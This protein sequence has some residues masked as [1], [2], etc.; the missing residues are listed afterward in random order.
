MNTFHDLMTRYAALHAAGEGESDEAQA[1][2]A[3][4]ISVAPPEFLQMAER[5]AQALGLMP[6]H[7]DGYLMDGS[8]VYTVDGIASRL[9]VTEAEVHDGIERMQA[10]QK[11]AG[12]LVQPL[13]FPADAVQR[14]Q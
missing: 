6:E 14:V 8:P 4:A 10:V 3:K 5:E 7:P 1:I 13:V 9:G 12:L 2:F 11:T